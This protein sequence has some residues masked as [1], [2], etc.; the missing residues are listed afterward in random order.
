MVSSTR[1]AAEPNTIH[2]ESVCEAVGILS[3]DLRGLKWAKSEHHGFPLITGVYENRLCLGVSKTFSLR[4]CPF[5]R[6][7]QQQPKNQCTQCELAFPVNLHQA[8]TVLN[9]API[10]SPTH[11]A[12]KFEWETGKCTYLPTPTLFSPTALTAMKITDEDRKLAPRFQRPTLVDVLPCHSEAVEQMKLACDPASAD[13]RVT[14]NQWDKVGALFPKVRL[15]YETST[16]Y[17]IATTL[18]VCPVCLYCCHRGTIECTVFDSCRRCDIMFCASWVDDAT[19]YHVYPKTF[20]WKGLDPVDFD[21]DGNLK[22]PGNVENLSDIAKRALRLE[23]DPAPSPS[24][25]AS[26]APPLDVLQASLSLAQKYLDGETRLRFQRAICVKAVTLSLG[27]QGDSLQEALPASFQDLESHDDMLKFVSRF[28]PDSQELQ[29]FLYSALW[30]DMEA[31][32]KK[33]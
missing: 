23:P 32:L 7:A 20:D 10:L 31:N 2:E 25:S 11:T 33:V 29:E 19:I 5:C 22:T 27:T 6:R 13:F 18:T 16:G 1:F 15:S 4:A 30:S 17:T 26:P 9:V 12:A 28:Y 8:K 21:G 3:H 14:S 24:P